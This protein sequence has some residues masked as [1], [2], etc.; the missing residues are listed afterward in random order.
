MIYKVEFKPRALKDLKGLPASESVRIVAKAEALQNGLEG[1]VKRLTH[2]TPEYRLRVGAH[3]KFLHVCVISL[4]ST[5]LWR[6]G[7]GRGGVLLQPLSLSLSPLAR[8]EGT[9]K[10]VFVKLRLPRKNGHRSCV[11]H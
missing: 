2:F 4:S 5:D 3:L 7:P 9:R 8:G 11:R 1:D 6:R 10:G